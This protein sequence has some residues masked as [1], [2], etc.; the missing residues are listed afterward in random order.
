MHAKDRPMFKHIQESTRRS[1]DNGILAFLCLGLLVA[2]WGTAVRIRQ[3]VDESR[4]LVQLAGTRMAEALDHELDIHA[5]NLR[6]M[7]YLAERFL[8]K[9]ALGMDSPTARLVPLA[10]ANG[11]E[12]VL[13]AA[14][15]DPSTLGR[16]TGAGRVPKA[17][18]PIALEMTM[19]IGLT[20]LMRAIKERSSDVAWV[21]YASARQFMFIFPRRGSEQFFFTPELL[22]RDYFA[23]A[24]PEANPG[25]AVFWS[26]PYQDAA[27]QGNIVTVSQPLYHG[28][29]FL[30]SVNIDFRVGS[31]GRLLGSAPIPGTEIRV[32]NQQG[33][34]I[35]ASSPDHGIRGQDTDEVISLPLRSA[36]WQVELRVNRNALLM[37]ALHGRAWHILPVLV[38][39][40]SLVFLILLMRS[41]R[42]AR[43]LAITDGLT[44]LY[45]RRH[46][47]TVAEHQ[48]KAA[49]RQGSTL[50]LVLMDIDFFKKYNDHY[51]HHQGDETLRAVAQALRATL[52]RGSDQVFRVGGEEFA[53]LLALKRDEELEP[54]LRKIN[55][56]I[57]DLRRPHVGH[58]AGQVT[59]S[60]GGIVVRAHDGVDVESAYRRADEALYQAKSSGRD[61]GII[62]RPLGTD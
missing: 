26:A 4:Q 36:P 61:R 38:L 13:P 9:R 41:H 5:Y 25:R 21:H 35:G 52:R 59:A 20:P 56:A 30:G 3:S 12:A 17:R 62:W 51:G 39:S 10:D 24:T 16:I 55:Q 43:N 23:L 45:N 50:G 22:K 40:V 28:N 8:D 49:R 18:D 19:A 1:I 47:D 32:V 6:A 46:F 31:L 60:L 29:T 44:G 14:Y 37:A 33:T 57:R 27:G 42:Q 34:V 15:G 7:K 54:L 48:F 58:P 53:A 2:I 11:Y